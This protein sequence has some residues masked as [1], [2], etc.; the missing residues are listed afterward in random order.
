MKKTNV[1]FFLAILLLLFVL[2]TMEHQATGNVVHEWLGITI[3]LIVFVHVL[4]HFE[5]IK[6]TT[7]LFFSGGTGIIRIK[8][9]LNILIF[10]DLITILFS[11]LMISREVLPGLS[12]QP[13]N[14]FFWRSVHHVS[15]DMLLIFTAIH[16]ALNWHRILNHFSKAFQ[17]GFTN[18]MKNIPEA[19]P[20]IPS[21]E[22]NAG[23]FLKPVNGTGYLKMLFILV[24][25]SAGIS[26]GW[27]LLAYT[28]MARPATEQVWREGQGAP[29]RF[30]RNRQRFHAGPDNIHHS[31][32][33]DHFSLTGILPGMMQNSAIIFLLVFVVVMTRDHFKSPTQKG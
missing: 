14:H 9:I 15:A 3:F 4:L 6:C 31:G 10:A 33:R 24:L 22:K 27:Y 18:Q 13:G 1:N 2:L 26:T 32:R 7:R 12:G 30:T 29:A 11:G 23:N 17:S 20:A 5:W 8:Y 25:L 28:S 19:L 16:I 21:P